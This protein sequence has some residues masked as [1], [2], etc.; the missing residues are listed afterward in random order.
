MCELTLPLILMRLN[1][2]AAEL[3]NHHL[4]YRLRKIKTDQ[5]KDAITRYQT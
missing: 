4:A 3:S 2:C 1:A 5:K